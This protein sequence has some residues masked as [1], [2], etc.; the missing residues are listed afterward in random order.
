M[1]LDRLLANLGCGSRREVARMIADGRVTGAD[2]TPVA[3]D[4]TASH[5]EIRLDGAPLDPL[6]PLTL[7]VHKPVG[8][9]C[10]ADDAGPLIYELLP[11]RF[12][13]R[14]PPLAVAGRL[15]KESSG[16]VVMTDDGALLHRIISPKKSVWKT[17]EAGLARP[18]SGK[19]RE[20]F[21]SGTL[22]LRGEHKPC[23]PALLE[24]LS[25][26]KARV[27]LSEGR[28]HQVRRMFAAVGN[29]VDSLHR[30]SLGNLHLGDLPVGQWRLAAA[31]DVAAILSN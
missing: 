28:Y 12:A 16:L 19:E 15:D 1:R 20:I 3:I 23:L 17:Y 24:V 31:A 22:R 4:G 13:R 11:P 14:K 9:T 8:F 26:R 10:S 7:V 29:H 30:S 2:G 6:P 21:S 5:A 25:D 18:L 27:R